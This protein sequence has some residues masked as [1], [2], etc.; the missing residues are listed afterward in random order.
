MLYNTCLVVYVCQ[1]GVCLDLL[2]VACFI[3]GVIGVLV[4]CDLHFIRCGFVF[5]M[6]IEF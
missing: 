6:L 1:F 2:A 3:R 5:S 4:C